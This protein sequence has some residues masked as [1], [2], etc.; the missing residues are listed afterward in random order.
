MAG[1]G[2]EAPAH[3][4]RAPALHAAVEAARA[5]EAGRG[6]VVVAADVRTLAQPSAQAAREVTSLIARTDAATGE[7][8]AG[9]T[10]VN[11]AASSLD[12]GKRQN[13]ALV[14]Q[15]AAAADSLRQQVEGLARLIST[16]RLTEIA[17]AA[18]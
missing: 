16:Y 18:A 6:F 15:S 17:D 7:Q 9:I 11:Q 13:A 12:N 14:E 3:G 8:S 5:G 4:R 2:A 1:Q 10:Q